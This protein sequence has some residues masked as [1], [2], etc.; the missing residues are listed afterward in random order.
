L[1]SPDPITS[2]GSRDSSFSINYPPELSTNTN[3]NSPIFTMLISSHCWF[4]KSYSIIFLSHKT[5]LHYSAALWLVCNGCV[6][7][8]DLGCSFLG[9]K[10]SF[11][12]VTCKRNMRNSWMLLA[13]FMPN[14]ILHHGERFF[15]QWCTPSQTTK[16]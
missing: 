2:S 1:L 11:S 15:F 12:Q 13:C 8:G 16:I 9:K 10:L 14:S 5:H 3:Y 6:R 4:P 7:G